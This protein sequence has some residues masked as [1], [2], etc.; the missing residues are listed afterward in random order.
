MNITEEFW[1]VDG[2]SLH[3][4]ASAIAT[5]EGRE[6]LPPRRGGN[7]VVSYRPGEVW[8]PKT[9]G[10]RDMALAMWVKGSDAD[11]VIP[12]AGARAQWRSNLEALKSLFGIIDREVVLTRRL[13]TLS[14]LLVQTARG[15]CMGTLEPS[16]SGPTLGALVADIHMADP[17]WYGADIV[18]AIPLA[19]ANIVHPGTAPVTRMIIRFTGPL[20]NPQLINQSTVPVISASYNGVIGVGEWVELD[21]DD[22]TARTQ[23]GVSVIGNV[24]H[25]GARSWMQFIPGV[26]GM[27]LNAASGSGSVTITFAPS[28]L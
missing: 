20:T 10:P 17:F 2:V 16:M 23:A 28:Y 6:G 14:G 7:Q 22:Y 4:W 25:S 21:T 11:G 26:N 27:V 1:E 8:R 18:T 13:R 24:T 19:G 3:T 12:I 5:L 9:F 15:E